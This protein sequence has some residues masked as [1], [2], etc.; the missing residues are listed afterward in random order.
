MASRAA[1]LTLQRNDAG[2]VLIGR[3]N[4]G[5]AQL[6]RLCSMMSGF[7]N[8]AKPSPTSSPPD[9]KVFSPNTLINYSI[10][11]D[12]VKYIRLPFSFYYFEPDSNVINNDGM[13]GK[14]YSPFG[15]VFGS[16]SHFIILS[17]WSADDAH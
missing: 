13:P 8:V 4:K 1:W 12:P 7:P 16:Y 17:F 6:V 11:I 15:S 14:P 3:S 2:T 9:E 5:S 10:A